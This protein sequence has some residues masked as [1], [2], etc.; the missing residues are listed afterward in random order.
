[1]QFEELSP[2]S[3]F[4][5]SPFGADILVGGRVLVLF[6][7]QVFEGFPLRCSF[8]CFDSVLLSIKYLDEF[9]VVTTNR[10]EDFV[11]LVDVHRVLG[12]KTDHF[13]GEQSK[14]CLLARI[15]LDFRT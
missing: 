5:R 3:N 2:L 4:F 9:L 6:E 11:H 1:M 7:R 10:V 15:H 13:L 14:V 12:A 8:G